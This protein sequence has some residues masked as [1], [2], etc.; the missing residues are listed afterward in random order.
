MTDIPV[1]ELV[2]RVKA[3]FAELGYGDAEVWVVLSPYTGEH[4]VVMSRYS[5]PA[6]VRWQARFV[7]GKKA[8]CWS[9]WSTNSGSHEIG[10]DCINGNCHNLGPRRPPRELLTPRKVN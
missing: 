9:C 3:C 10:L 5:A 6:A 7:A 1:E 4:E 2:R 8:A